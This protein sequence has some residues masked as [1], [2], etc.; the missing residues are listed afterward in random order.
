MRALVNTPS[1]TQPAPLNP[2]EMKN[3][4]ALIVE[5]ATNAD[6]VAAPSSPTITKEKEEDEELAI[7]ED[8]DDDVA[9]DNE[10]E[11]ALASKSPSNP[12][13][14]NSASSVAAVIQKNDGIEEEDV[15]SQTNWEDFLED[16]SL[17]EESTN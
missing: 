8:I 16:E 6:V 10:L 17:A 11:A 5:Q 7:Y 9:V 4:G 3:N 13:N 1:Q 14:N 2:T 15:T 12:K